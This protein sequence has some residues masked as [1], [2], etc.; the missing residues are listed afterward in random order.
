MKV[1]VVVRKQT[2]FLDMQV[3]AVTDDRH[4]ADSIV[5]H[6]MQH[7][8]L[9]DYPLFLSDYDVVEKELEFPTFEDSWKYPW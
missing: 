9:D 7:L 4:T 8:L 3:V 6:D 2:S 5:I 1:Y